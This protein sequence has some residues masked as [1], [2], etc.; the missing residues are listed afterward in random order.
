MQYSIL[1][2]L[3]FSVVLQASGC[4]KSADT[5][6]PVIVEVEEAG[7]NEVADAAEPLDSSFCGDL[8]AICP[9]LWRLIQQH[10]PRRSDVQYSTSLMFKPE[11]ASYVLDSLVREGPT[12]GRS[13]NL[14]EDLASDSPT[15]SPV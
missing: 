8:V 6:P 10:P 14:N 5:S 1:C 7:V 2:A 3:A 15:H 12:D 9:E 11:V 13:H 4:E